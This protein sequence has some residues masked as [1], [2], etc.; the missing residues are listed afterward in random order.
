MFW[1]PWWWWPESHLSLPL[2]WNSDTAVAQ[3]WCRTFTAAH[4][5]ASWDSG[6]RRMDSESPSKS[7]LDAVR[8]FTGLS[9]TWKGLHV[10]A[11]LAHRNF[12][13]VL[14]CLPLGS[15]CS[16]HVTSWC[17]SG[18]GL[19]K[20]RSFISLFPH[21]S[22]FHQISSPLGPFIV[23][24]QWLHC[25]ERLSLPVSSFLLTFLFSP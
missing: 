14:T 20:N 4:A 19:W 5:N 22:H 18:W 12:L 6:M 9:L 10:P 21:L 13:T 17:L 15:W 1:V 23:G 24:Y 8:L 25:R 7:R 11:S 16:I 3:S 2:S